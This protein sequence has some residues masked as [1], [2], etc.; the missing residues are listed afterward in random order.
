VCRVYNAYIAVFRKPT[1]VPD[2]EKELIIL[3]TAWLSRGN[4]IWGRH[5]PYGRQ[6]GLTEEEIRRVTLGPEAPG[7]NQ[8]D[9]ALLKAVD[10]LHMSR[11]ISD[12]TWNKLGQNYSEAQRV[13]VVLI[14]GNYTQLAMY[15]NTVGTQLRPDEK[16][17]PDDSAGR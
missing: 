17:L 4:L 10:E 9:A 14:V 3:R 16:G 11:F 7:W 6:A 13:E 2:R 15:Q 5:D 8:L 12:G 1:T